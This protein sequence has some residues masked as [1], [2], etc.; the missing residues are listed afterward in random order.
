MVPGTERVRRAYCV[1]KTLYREFARRGTH[2]YAHDFP[3]SLVSFCTAR[4]GEKKIRY[5]FGFTS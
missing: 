3:R 4:Y 1:V 5:F 2:L